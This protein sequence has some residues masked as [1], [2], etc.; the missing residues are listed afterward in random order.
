MLQG[1]Q[2]G[3]VVSILGGFKPQLNEALSSLTSELTMLWAGGWAEDPL[4]SLPG[5]DS[6]LPPQSLFWGDL[7]YSE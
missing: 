4:R 2:R 5:F 3:C 6:L 7:R 1:A